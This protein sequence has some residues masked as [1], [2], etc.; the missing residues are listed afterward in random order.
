MVDRL[1]SKSSAERRGG[2]SPLLGNKGVSYVETV[3]ELVLDGDC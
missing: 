3:C 2:S 1:D